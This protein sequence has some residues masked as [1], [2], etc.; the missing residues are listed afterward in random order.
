MLS[1]AAKWACAQ[2]AY[3]VITPT[4]VN[5]YENSVADAKVIGMLQPKQS[6]EVYV[7]NGDWAIVKYNNGVG[8]VPGACLKKA[9]KPAAQQPAAE[10]AKPAAETVKPAVAPAVPQQAQPEKPAAPVAVPAE[11]AR[12][13]PEPV[14]FGYP[15]D[16]FH[17]PY[18]TYSLIS[19]KNNIARVLD[20]PSQMYLSLGYQRAELA[21]EIQF[22]PETLCQ[23]P[24]VGP[25][26]SGRLFRT[27]HEQQAFVCFGG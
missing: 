21:D 13:Q 15:G 19:K 11:P 14:S 12:Q 7:V 4:P 8:Y 18:H 5:V 27:G 16:G 24:P 3:V 17:R 9:E 22:G 1:L 26:R 10:T 25:H 6:V 23:Y 2:E 20:C